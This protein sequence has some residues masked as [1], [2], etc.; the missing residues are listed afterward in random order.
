ML[1]FLTSHQYLMV[2][3]PYNHVG[4]NKYFVD[5]IRDHKN[6]TIVSTYLLLCDVIKV[7]IV[8]KILYI[9]HIERNI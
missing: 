3:F 2:H 7:R 8:I 4:S 6:K 5:G 9:K 1:D